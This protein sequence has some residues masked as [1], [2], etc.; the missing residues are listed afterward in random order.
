MA[1]FREISR[2]YAFIYRL[3]LW[4]V[5]RSFDFIFST[6]RIMFSKFSFDT[7]CMNTKLENPKAETI[8]KL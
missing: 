5:F 8:F 4:A 2:K 7:C 1:I 6:Y 3:D